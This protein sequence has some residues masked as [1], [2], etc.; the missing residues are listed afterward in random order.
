[1]PGVVYVCV[2]FVAVESSVP[3]PS[4]SH[5]YVIGK[6]VGPSGSLGSPVNVTVSGA[7]PAWGTAAGALGP[8][9]ACTI[10]LSVALAVPPLPSSTV[11]RTVR[12]WKDDVVYVFVGFCSVDV[13]PSPKSHRYVSVS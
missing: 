8:R 13:V 2:G 7:K 1:M 10:T 5:E 4:K 6:W 9:L 12:G 3:S 11:T